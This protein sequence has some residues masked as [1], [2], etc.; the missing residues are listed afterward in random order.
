[1]FINNLVLLP[2]IFIL[3]RILNLHYTQG[4]IRYLIVPNH[5]LTYLLLSESCFRL[6]LSK[7]E[8]KIEH[9]FRASL[10]IERTRSIHIIEIER[11]LCLTHSLRHI[12]MCDGKLFQQTKWP[13]I[14]KQYIF[15]SI[16]ILFHWFTNKKD[17]GIALFFEIIIIE[18]IK[19]R[20]YNWP[21]FWYKREPNI[22]ELH[23]LLLLENTK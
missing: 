1:M 23:F 13:L 3:N 6:A 19:Y 16:F 4:F 12:I 17:F 8:G 14:Q 10:K 20:V 15:D 21:D 5:V 7:G 9:Y 2:H 22:Y 18:M 11:K